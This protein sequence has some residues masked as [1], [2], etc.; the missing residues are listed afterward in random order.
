MIQ[1]QSRSLIDSDLNGVHQ[2]DLNDFN[3][4][5]EDLLLSISNG[6]ASSIEYFRY[7]KNY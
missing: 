2:K 1:N 5:D 6:N 4:D 7:E 3:D